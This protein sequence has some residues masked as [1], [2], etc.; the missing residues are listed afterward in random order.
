MNF[1]IEPIK[2]SKS[3]LLYILLVL[4]YSFGLFSESTGL[5]KEFVDTYEDWIYLLRQNVIIVFASGTTA[6]LLG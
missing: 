2:R 4:A 6:S 5:I 1:V 3:L